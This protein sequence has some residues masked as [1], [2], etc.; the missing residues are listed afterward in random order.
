MHLKLP[1]LKA[2]DII[3]VLQHD[4]WYEVEARGG[5]RAFEHPY[6]RGKVTVPIHGGKDVPRWVL[7]RVLKQ[8]GLAANEFLKLL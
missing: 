7:E 8:A 1:I 2:R 5:H 4:G 6:K 3:R